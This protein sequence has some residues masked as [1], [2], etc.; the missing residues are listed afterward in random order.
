[1]L[2]GL[3]QPGVMRMDFQPHVQMEMFAPKPRRSGDDVIE[4]TSY[5]KALCSYLFD[6]C[7]CHKTIASK[8]EISKH[9]SKDATLYTN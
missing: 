4:S 7:L 1:M 3:D 6:G 2:F 9:G 5:T 8:K